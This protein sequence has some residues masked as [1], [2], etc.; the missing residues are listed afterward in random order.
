M[1]QEEVEKRMR[2]VTFRTLKRGSENYRKVAL[3]V[4]KDLNLELLV[5]A[6]G[7]WEA[8]YL[9]SSMLNK[10]RKVEQRFHA[11]YETSR[12]S[13]AKSQSCLGRK[14][15]QILILEVHVIRFFALDSPSSSE[16]LE[17][18]TSS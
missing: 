11:I 2:R 16:L 1:E 14:K 4:G 5:N 18:S 7:P 12:R 17:E 9:V 10:R 15:T 8:K 3:M 6:A 13:F